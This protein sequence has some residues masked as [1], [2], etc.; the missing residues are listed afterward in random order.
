VSLSL[1]NPNSGTTLGQSSATLT[2]NDDDGA[3][4][5]S[6]TPTASP[7]PSATP[8]PS[9]TASPSPTAA[10]LVVHIIQ[11]NR[12]GDKGSITSR[13]V[14]EHIAKNA[15]VQLKRAGQADINGDAQISLKELDEWIRPR[16]AREARKANR[17]QT[18]SVQVGKKL[19]APDDF[20]VAWGYA[21]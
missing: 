8:T 3:P 17:E 20:I 15:I 13:I 7:T 2:I 10:P 5:P 11:P 6:P 12:G 16:V 4:P 14:G 9:P 18:P 1:S 21:R 19:G